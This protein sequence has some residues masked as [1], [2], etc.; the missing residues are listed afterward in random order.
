MK[1]LFKRLIC[2]VI[3]AI[4]CFSSLQI[5][6][7]FATDEP[8]LSIKCETV[9][10]VTGKEGGFGT[11][12]S[13]LRTKTAVKLPSVINLSNAD[14]FEFDVYIEDIDALKAVFEESWKVNFGFSSNARANTA[15]RA[16]ANI[17]DQLV[18]NGWNH[19]EISKSAFVESN[20]NWAS[21][22]HYYLKFAD[23]SAV[24]PNNLQN[25]TVKI[26]NICESFAT[27]ELTDGDVVLFDNAVFGKLGNDADSPLS[28]IGETF[29]TVTYTC[30]LSESTFLK[31]DLLIPALTEFNAFVA[32]KDFKF[33]LT[34]NDG[35]AEYIFKGAYFA[36]TVSD[37]YTIQLPIN[38]FVKSADFDIANVTGFRVEIDGQD[39]TVGSAYSLVF[40]FANIRAINCAL[41]EGDI[42]Y[43]EVVED[44]NVFNKVLEF[45]NTFGDFNLTIGSGLDAL[46]DTENIEFDLYVEN[47]ESFNDF[48]V[49]DKNNNP[50]DASLDLVLSNA[51]NTLKW[52]NVQD[53]ILANGWN[54]IILSVADA[55]NNGFNLSNGFDNFKFEISGVDKNVA[56][57]NFGEFLIVTKLFATKG[58]AD[59]NELVYDKQVVLSEGKSQNLGNTFAPLS[60]KVSTPGDFTNAKL[61]E[62]DI[63]IQNFES[64]K[65]LMGAKGI[66]NISLRLSSN[67]DDYS[68]DSVTANILDRIAQDGWNHIAISLTNFV[69]GDTTGT[70]DPASVSAW[71]LLFNGDSAA[72]TGILE[73]QKIAVKNITSVTVEDPK[74]PETVNP[75]I[76][77]EGKTGVYGNTYK[78][79]FTNSK[80]DLS[81]PVDATVYSNLQ[82][83]FYVEDYNA[84]KKMLSNASDTLR[85]GLATSS[86]KKDGKA[87]YEF[88]DQVIGQGWNRIVVKR[89]DFTSPSG[90]STPNFKTVYSAF[91]TF[92]DDATANTYGNTNFKIINV[93]SVPHEQDIAPEAPEYVV[94]IWKEGMLSRWGTKFID[95]KLTIQKKSSTPIDISDADVI[96]FD[97]YVDD[98]DAFMDAAE[99]GNLCFILGSAGNM[100]D[101]IATYK[102]SDQITHQGWNHVKM[103]KSSYSINWSI[104]FANIK[105]VYLCY[106][107]SAAQNSPN[108]IGDTLV[109]IANIVATYGEFRNNPALPENVISVLGD[110]KGPFFEGNSLGQKY[111]FTLDRIY[112][113]RFQPIDFHRSNKIEFD[114]YIEDYEKF[115]AAENDPKDTRDSKLCLELSSTAPGLWD[116]YS[117]PR[118]YFTSGI[119]LADY[120][121][122]SGWNHVV[123]SKQDFIK[124]SNNGV[125]WSAITAFA[126]FY[127]GSSNV[128]PVDHPYPDLYVRVANIC[129]TG[130]I[131]EPPKDEDKPVKHDKSAVYISSVDGMADETGIWETEGGYV[132][133]DYKTEGLGSIHQ[134]VAY[135]ET[136]EDTRM[137]YLFDDSVDMSDIKT[138]KF[139]FFIDVPAHI[140]RPGNNI[141]ILIGNNRFG[142]DKYYSW[143]MDISSL[144]MGWNSIELPINEA[145]KVGTPDL[146]TVK[147]VMLRFTE[148]DLD[149]EEYAI[150]VY[151]IDNLRYISATGNKTLRIEGW[152]DV[153]DEEIE[154]EYDDS[155]DDDY[156]IEDDDE[157]DTD[158]EII[159]EEETDK[160]EKI[161]TI[162]NKVGDVKYNRVLEKA[163]VMD[164]TGIIILL[165][166]EAVVIVA[167][168]VVFT[169]I[170]EKK[171][172]KRN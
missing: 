34:S 136:I 3:V 108:P 97:I 2:L 140:Q 30:D 44:Y 27:P 154:D 83:D 81:T 1:L 125:D 150:I 76:S 59:K 94:D 156:L 54:H 52:S 151:G 132:S 42:V 87:L 114:I 73:G 88:T 46:N 36:S 111:H 167:G 161:E 137:F 74:L 103:N 100:N 10:D 124:L 112:V 68:K 17:S 39:A 134:Q 98:Y 57:K 38:N 65:T 127:K 107:S 13:G 148:M 69:K 96:E 144:V 138:L 31:T 8:E 43:G 77:E 86:N 164:Y 71:A 16:D 115:L 169:I 139:D 116:Q 7:I 62:F 80:I 149:A 153:L 49:F 15:N 22:R 75:V 117:A 32:N 143:N 166:I 9:I 4:L 172:K 171:S 41:P 99:V 37:W 160:V 35:E 162:V 40:G 120:I 146:T 63:Y 28:G 53:K 20:I 133:N 158:F 129:N 130:I 60:E 33:V 58:D 106:W 118:H 126:L 102:F 61:V 45:G 85:F 21:V 121:T 91:L 84:F 113:Q 50:V 95:T 48:F 82:F 141:E 135:T 119:L 104:D 90:D 101:N 131:A 155:F 128:Y 47:I 23:E 66:S 19:I 18:E 165:V 152:D 11:S 26:K 168:L 24:L 72:A 110:K 55:Q 67:G 56:S 64:F 147:S 92:G 5:I 109:H 93:C 122:H 89:T 70:F 170:S 79:T 123:V 157:I 29:N 142:R 6:D 163:T 159:E 25:K 51:G 78:D 14:A 145:T 12:A 105:W